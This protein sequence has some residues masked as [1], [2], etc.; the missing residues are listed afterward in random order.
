MIPDLKEAYQ[1]AS[2]RTKLLILAALVSQAAIA[3]YEQDRRSLKDPHLSRMC[4][5]QQGVFEVT[6]VGPITNIY[7]K[8]GE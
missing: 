1:K 3:L 2:K 5:V 4:F 7:C 8:R 6:R